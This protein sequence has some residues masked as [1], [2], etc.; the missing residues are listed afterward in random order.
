MKE[1]FQQNSFFEYFW[2]LSF[3][4]IVA[5]VVVVVAVVVAVVVVVVVVVVAGAEMSTCLRRLQIRTDHFIRTFCQSSDVSKFF[6]TEVK[7]RKFHDL[8]F[9]L[10]S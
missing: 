6:S 7:L 8:Q 2:N 5:A 10:S 1:I 3:F 4:G 9:N